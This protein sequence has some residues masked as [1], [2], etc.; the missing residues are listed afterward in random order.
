MF[1]RLSSKK[2]LLQDVSLDDEILAWEP[3]EEKKPIMPG[4]LAARKANLKTIPQSKLLP[5][6]ILL[7]LSESSHV[8]KDA[9]IW[10]NNAQKI[11][12]KC[13]I[14]IFRSID[15][16]FGKMIAE[17]AD[18]TAH[19]GTKLVTEAIAEASIDPDMY[20]IQNSMNYRLSR[21]TKN[22]QELEAELF[23][24]PQYKMLFFINQQAGNPY[25]LLCS[26]VD[27]HLVR[28]SEQTTERAQK[29][30][31]D[32]SKVYETS[33][34]MLKQ[35]W[36]SKLSPDG[37]AQKLLSWMEKPFAVNTGYGIRTPLSLGALNTVRKS[38]S[39]FQS[40]IE[41]GEGSPDTCLHPKQPYSR[42]PQR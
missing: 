30:H 10:G 12:E 23:K 28:L 41:R 25:K 5:G 19:K 38:F 4:L 36:D 2:P 11:N 1:D 20:Y 31:T 22:L 18:F 14:L 27:R 21:S 33:K 24:N 39:I 35:F 9:T 37:K 13:P 16:S 7:F 34:A 26:E 3:K 17:K 29:K 8:V 40:V 6:D 32:S 15:K 42:N